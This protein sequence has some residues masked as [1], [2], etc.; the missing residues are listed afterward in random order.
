M[1]DKRT[2][3][4][5]SSWR[6]SADKAGSVLKLLQ[7]NNKFASMQQIRPNGKVCLKLCIEDYKNT[8]F[9]CICIMLASCLRIEL[10]PM[11]LQQLSHTRVQ[12]RE[13]VTHSYV[14]HYL[15]FLLYINQLI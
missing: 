8:S 9:L 13:G 10:H 11:N 15:Q 1:P 4:S 12:L 7:D 14:I 3:Q 2:Y 5:F 6:F